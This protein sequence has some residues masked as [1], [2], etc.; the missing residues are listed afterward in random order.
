MQFSVILRILK[1]QYS[2]ISFLLAFAGLIFFN[3]AVS[4]AQGDLLLFP[5]RVVF[6]GG[7]RSEIINL[8]NTGNDTVKYDISFV[9]IRMNEDGSFETITEPDAGQ[10]FASPFIRY[11]PRTVTLAPRESQVVKLQLT[12]TNVLLPGEYRSHLYFRA[13]PTQKSL[14]EKETPV[15]TTS[16]SIRL[17]QLYGITIPCIIHVDESTTNVTLSNLRF[18]RDK[19]SVPCIHAEFHRSG[20]MSAYGNITVNYESTEGKTTTVG[21]VNGF[22][23]YTPGSIRRCIITLQELEGVDYT[24]GI[25]TLNYLTPP[26]SKSIK[27]ASA[28]VA[29]F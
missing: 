12:K 27:L 14:A 2:S 21:Q 5:K 25:L 19:N 3:S 4:L 16:L 18:E 28:E 9:Q 6:E 11:Y 7:K 8:S 29:L 10:L 15:D 23:I 26:A 1:Y 22:A 24:R 20:N 13:E 17:I